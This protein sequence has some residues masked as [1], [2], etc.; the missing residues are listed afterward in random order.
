[1]KSI[2]F[3]IFFVAWQA[4]AGPIKVRSVSDMDF[5]ISPQGDGSKVVS[6]GTTETAT[7][8]SFRVTGDNN[9]AYSIVLPSSP[10]TMTT[11]GNGIKTIGVSNFLSFPTPSTGGQLN[12]AGEQM[13]Y[14]GAT[15]DA[16]NPAQKAG[17][18]SGTFSVTVVY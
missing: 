11:N 14:V 4:H 16:L 3:F 8:A 9:S 5:G 18:Y 13:I 17:S 12:G 2:I 7:N 15:R 6:A 10:I 1:M